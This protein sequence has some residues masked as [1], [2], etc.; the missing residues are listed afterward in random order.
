[1]EHV[2][3]ETTCSPFWRPDNH[4]GTLHL[5]F[6]PM[7][8]NKTTELNNEL[9]EFSDVG[10]KVLKITHMIDDRDDAAASDNSGSTHNSSYT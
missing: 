4:V 3:D 1:M 6:G 7:F 9:T 5:K 2:N 10:F 8:S